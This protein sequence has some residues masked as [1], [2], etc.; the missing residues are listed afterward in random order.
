MR[1]D[2]YLRRVLQRGLMREWQHID[3]SESYASTETVRPRR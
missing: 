1:V 2:G 3:Q